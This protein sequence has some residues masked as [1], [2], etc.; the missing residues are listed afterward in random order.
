MSQSPDVVEPTT[1]RG[2]IDPPKLIEHSTRGCCDMATT[3]DINWDN[4]VFES[5]KNHPQNECANFLLSGRPTDCIKIKRIFLTDVV[6]FHG[7]CTPLGYY[8]N[9]STDCPVLYSTQSVINVHCNHVQTCEY[10]LS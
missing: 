1:P 4:M 3:E 5:C 10:N 8:C 6:S 9:T 7:V 2:P